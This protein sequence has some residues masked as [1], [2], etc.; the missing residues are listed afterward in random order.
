MT[1]IYLD[2]SGNLGFSKVSGD[3]FVVAAICSETE[4]EVNQCIKNARSGLTK[5]YKKNEMKFSNSSDPTRKR[6][7]KCI[8]KRDISCHYMA[9]TKKWIHPHLREKKSVLQS[10]AFSQLLCNIMSTR[11]G[12]DLNIVVDKFL[13]SDKQIEKFNECI[14]RKIRANPEIEHVSSKSSRGI[15]AV[16]FVA[17]AAH[18]K[19]RN[20]DGSFINIISD[21]IEMEIDLRTEIFRK[22]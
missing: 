1:Y 2:E 22:V 6:I 4:K 7:L 20:S 15:Q 3:F 9:I 12:Y 8:N 18:R 21:K 10:Y 11:S 13:N 14:S 16:D 17:G 5:K 19:Y